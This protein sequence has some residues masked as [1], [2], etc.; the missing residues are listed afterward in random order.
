MSEQSGKKFYASLTHSITSAHHKD[1]TIQ[2]LVAGENPNITQSMLNT[3][4]KNAQDTA[5]E[6]MPGIEITGVAL[7]ARIDL[8]YMT[9]AEFTGQVAAEES[10][11]ETLQ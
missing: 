4:G 8:G 7:I 1:L 2:V 9:E 5:R 6:I 10:A 11:Q 3:A